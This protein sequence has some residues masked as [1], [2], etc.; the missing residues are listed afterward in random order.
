MA[1][2]SVRD[3][4]AALALLEEVRYVELTDRA[5][6]N[7]R[8]IDQLNFARVRTTPS[9]GGAVE[10]SPAAPWPRH[11]REIAARRGWQLAVRPLPGRLHNRPQKITQSCERALFRPG[12]GAAVLAY[13]DCGTYGELDELCAAK[14]S[15][16]ASP[17]STATTS[18]PAPSVI[19]ATLRRRAR[20]LPADRLPGPSFD[21]SGN[22]APGPDRH[23]ELWPDYFGHYTP[24]GLAGAS[25]NPRARSRGP[26]HSQPLRPAPDTIAT[27]LA[28]L[29]AALATVLDGVGV[30]TPATTASE[31]QPQSDPR[32]D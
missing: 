18:T 8:F 19:A 11:I 13:A 4:A 24:S 20:H 31:A 2:L 22:Q 28:G 32:R 1:L 9:N 16:A 5:D 27:G 25:A 17:A 7:D 26:A 30:W 3:R 29:E 21:N 12:H 10:S 14:A 15:P 6:F 23:P